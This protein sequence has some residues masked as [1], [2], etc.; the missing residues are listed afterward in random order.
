MQKIQNFLSKHGLI[1]FAILALLIVLYL[2]YAAGKKAGS[3]NPVVVDDNGA[4]VSPSPEQKAQA[5][6]IATRIH[7]DLDSGLLA[8][9]NFFSAF[10]RDTEAYTILSTMSDSMFAFTVTTYHTLFNTSLLADIT[11]ESSLATGGVGSSQSPKDIILL[12]ATRL[13]LS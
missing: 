1:I 3:G 8:G 12:K 13:N 5:T 7:N 6:A 4:I 11:A 10:S 9:Y 2:I